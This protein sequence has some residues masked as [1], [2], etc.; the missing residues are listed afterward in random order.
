[1]R[2][3]K[4]DIAYEFPELFSGEERPAFPEPL[5]DDS[6]IRI[7]ADGLSHD[8]TALR[9]Q[10]MLSFIL[11]TA[12]EERLQ[13]VEAA[14]VLVMEHPSSGRVAAVR[15]EDPHK[16]YP[17]RT[18]SNLGPGDAGPLAGED[19]DTSGGFL[20]IPLEIEI[21]ESGDQPSLFL[22]V[23]LAHLVSNTLAIDVAELRAQSY[24]D[25]RAVDLEF[26]H[27]D[28]EEGEDEDEESDVE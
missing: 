3:W 19:D 6:G 5:E 24:L 16:R 22:R 20:E 17:P 11:P 27:P 15:L 28:D 4:E 18:G 1:M 26:L 8:G 13:S 2:M 7:T 9:L 23:V 21:P 12:F 14:L 25:G 10:L